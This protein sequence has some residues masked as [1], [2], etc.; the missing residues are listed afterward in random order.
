LLDSQG[1]VVNTPG[2]EGEIVGTGFINTVV[3]FI[4]Y[5]TGD[6]ATYVSDRCEACGRKHVIINNIKGRWP[7]GGLI[8]SDGSLVSMTALNV[9]DDTFENVR[10]YQFRQSEP[11]TAR[12]CVVPSVSLDADQQQKI[13]SSM[14]KRLQGQVVV[15]LEICSELLKTSQGKQL[16]VVQEAASNQ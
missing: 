3:P 1:N 8:A 15:T 10:E 16:R 9:H 11:G 12:L 5:R 13:T 7:Q 4:R 6:F 14:N 2:A